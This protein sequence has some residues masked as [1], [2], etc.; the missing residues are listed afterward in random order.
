MKFKINKNHVSIR[1]RA[2][3][4]VRWLS[5]RA[6]KASGGILLGRA[7]HLNVTISDCSTSSCTEASAV[8][9]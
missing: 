5:I 2:G 9:L 6:S 3:S 8:L 4:H 7:N 1:S